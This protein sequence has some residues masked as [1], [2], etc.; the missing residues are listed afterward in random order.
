MGKDRSQTSRFEQKYIITEDLA[1]QIRDFVGPH[2]EL[3]ENAVGRANYSYPVHTLYL[4]SADLKLY[5]G[6]IDR[7]KSRFKLRLRYYDDKPDAPVFLEI[8]QRMSTYR[9]KKRAAVRRDLVDRLLAGHR[10]EPS[11]LVSNDLEY[12]SA[13][14]EFCE[15]MRHI[16]ARPRI[17]IGYLREAYMP[18][19]DNSTRLTLDREVRV[20]PEPA[21]RLSTTMQSP[22]PLWGED[23]VL[24]LKYTHGLPVWFRD[25]MSTFNLRLCGAA[26]YVDA[27]A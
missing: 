18:H 20:E 8:K 2:L 4:D 16:D 17:H 7:D 27:V 15:R 14:E 10:P 23:V 3:D 9:M 13:L 21:A 25:L 26:K 12:L 11:Y 6:A 1:L 22:A 24:E 19:D 5:W